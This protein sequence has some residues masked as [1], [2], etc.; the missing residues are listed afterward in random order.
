MWWMGYCIG[1]CSNSGCAIN[2]IFGFYPI[3][4][5]AVKLHHCQGLHA[6][7]APAQLRYNQSPIIERVQVE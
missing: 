4:D 3:D 6:Y 5:A 2:L 1:G 7:L